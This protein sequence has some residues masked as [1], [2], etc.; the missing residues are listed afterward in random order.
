MFTMTPVFASTQYA[1]SF[2]KVVDTQAFN[3][4]ADGVVQISY[5]GSGSFSLYG[6]TLA[7]QNVSEIQV[8]IM[9]QRWNGLWWAD[10]ATFSDVNYNSDRV[11]I[12]RSVTAPTGYYYRLKGR[13]TVKHGGVIEVAFSQTP[14]I[15]AK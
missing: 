5:W 7:S 9:L 13:H 1:E 14:A 6:R 2:E 12:S 11:I 8:D 15:Y 3:Y 10:I 4:L